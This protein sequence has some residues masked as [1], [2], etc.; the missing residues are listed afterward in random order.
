MRW[1]KKELALQNLFQKLHDPTLLPLLSHLKS[2]EA[3]D[4]LKSLWITSESRHQKPL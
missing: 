1:Y 4:T 2:P 3:D